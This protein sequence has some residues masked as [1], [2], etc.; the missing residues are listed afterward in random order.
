ME[1]GHLVRDFGS[2]CKLLSWDSGED[3]VLLRMYTKRRST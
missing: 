2:F 1:G 3:D